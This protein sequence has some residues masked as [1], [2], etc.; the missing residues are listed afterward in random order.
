MSWTLDPQHGSIEFA[1]R[2]MVVSTVKGRFRD[3]TIEALIDEDDLAR[4]SGRVSIRTGSVDT[5]EEKRDAHLRSPD[6]FDSE[7]YPDMVFEVTRI[8]GAEGEFQ[9]IGDL[10]IKDVTREV[11]LDAEVTGPIADPWGAKRLGISASGRLNRKDFGLVWNVVTE[12]GG[13][14]VADDVRLSVEAE[15]VFAQQPAA[16]NVPA[17]DA[18]GS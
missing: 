18:V 2:H 6:F 5:H 8:E 16:E 11:T 4:S 14:L 17:G 12:T 1:V 9:V 15:F 7:R 3:F 13:L 10:T